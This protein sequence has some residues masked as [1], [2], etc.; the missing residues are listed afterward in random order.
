MAPRSWYSKR[1]PTSCRVL[2]AITTLFGSAIACSR[3]ARL[4]VSP[5]MPRSCASPRPIRSPTITGP[6]PMP[7]RTCS[8]WVAALPSVSTALIR[9]NPSPHRSFGVIFVRLR[10]AKI[11]EHS[12]PHVL[13]DET[14]K[15]A[16]RV[17]DTALIRA[18]HL[19]Q[20]LGIQLACKCRRTDKVHEH[21]SELPPFGFHHLV[22]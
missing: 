3:A 4:G 20:I 5:T 18:D 14:V 15:P 2:A 19:A 8:S 17:G 7:M 21:H 1:S 13:S 9:A 22:F 12:V 10:I 16:D 11:D 6:V